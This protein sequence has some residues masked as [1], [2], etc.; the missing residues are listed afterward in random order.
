[1][2]N[3]VLDEIKR[4]KVVPVVVI[5]KIEEAKPLMAALVE[6]DVPVAEVTFRT[7]VAKDAIALLTKE[8][9]DA[10]IGAGTVINKEQAY[11]AIEAGA[12][13]IVSPGLS[14]EV[15]E[16]CKEKGIPYVPGIVTPTEIMEALSLGLTHL[17]FFPAG[18]FGGL[19]AIKAMGAAFP[20][21]SFMPTGGVDL[22]NLAEFVKNPKIFAIGGSFLTKGTHEEIVSN[23]LAA[24]KIVKENM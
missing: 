18:V 16:V 21:V 15:Y 9:P 6:G 4:I 7:A 22:T 24:R 19:K 5:N 10:L 11:E 17:K 3:K 1:M 8:Y 13:F 2:D 23:C 14:K 12:K 20:A